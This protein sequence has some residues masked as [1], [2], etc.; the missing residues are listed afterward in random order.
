MNRIVT[1]VIIFLVATLAGCNDA[2]PPK[3]EVRV[4]SASEAARND[5]RA[6]AVRLAQQ[7]AAVDE[8][9][10]RERIRELRQRSV[11]A[12]RAISSR[13]DQSLDEA[14]RTF[15]SEIAGVIKKLQTIKNDMESVEVDDCTS[16][17]RAT[18]ASSMDATIEGLNIFQSETGTGTGA[19]ALKLQSGS[20]ILYA[21]QREVNACAPK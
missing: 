21:A 7:K 20:D 8:A 17:A 19:S 6:I 14:N 12:L 11:D 5:D 4:E 3:S 13:W 2:T 16:G 1:L 10:A 18:L 15:R 9:Y